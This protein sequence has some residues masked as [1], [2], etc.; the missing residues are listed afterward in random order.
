M[1]KITLKRGEKGMAATLG[2]S[3]GR[4]HQM[5]VKGSEVSADLLQKYMREGSFDTSIA[6]VDIIE[7]IGP[8]TPEELALVSYVLPHL[9]HAMRAMAG[10]EEDTSDLHTILSK[11]IL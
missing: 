4:A 2:I 8:E 11:G 9:M 10:G 7:G 1:L 3:D 5:S 6:S